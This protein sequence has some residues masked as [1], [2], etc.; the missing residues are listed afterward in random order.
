[1]AHFIRPCPHVSPQWLSEWTGGGREQ[2]SERG[3]RKRRDTTGYEPLEQEREV[4][5]AT[6]L[7]L[8]VDTICMSMVR[9]YKCQHKKIVV[10]RLRMMEQGLSGQL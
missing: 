6:A 7:T 4:D 10:R 8:R 5:F 2:E 9:A 1:M 3:E